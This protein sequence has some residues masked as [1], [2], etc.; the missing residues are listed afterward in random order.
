MQVTARMTVAWPSPVTTVSVDFSTAKQSAS[1]PWAS[2]AP[3]ARLP[4]T[5]RSV[6][7]EAL[8]CDLRSVLGWEILGQVLHPLSGAGGLRPPLAQSWGQLEAGE[9][10]RAPAVQRGHGRGGRRLPVPGHVWR[11]R[12]ARD[13]GRVGGGEVSGGAE[14]GAGAVAHSP[15]VEGG[16]GGLPYCRLS[17]SCESEPGNGANSLSSLRPLARWRD[18][19]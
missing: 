11:L 2:L 9:W 8:S 17:D 5:S 15:G 1:V 16:R 12:G 18:G 6:R 19:Q 10:G 4:G 3:S 7:A 14:A 13:G